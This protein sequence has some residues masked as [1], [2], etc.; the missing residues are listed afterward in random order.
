MKNR[1]NIQFIVIDYLQLISCEKK[2]CLSRNIQLK[3]IMRKLK[4]LSKDLNIPILLLSQLSRLPEKRKNHRPILSDFTANKVAIDTYADIVLF[5]YRDA[6]YSNDKSNIAEIIIA[7]NPSGL[8]YIE[9]AWMPEYLKFGN[10]LKVRKDNF[11][12][13]N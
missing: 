8:D 10:L 13:E 1:E 3:E 4:A 2:D 9:L 6:Y 12:G 5:L 7:K 11:Y